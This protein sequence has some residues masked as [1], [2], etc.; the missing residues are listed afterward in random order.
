[1]ISQGVFLM[2]CNIVETERIAEVLKE[3]WKRLGVSK[4]ILTKQGT[5]FVSELGRQVSK[6]L[7]VKGIVKENKSA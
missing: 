6:L 4:E 2:L 1:M 3:M 7:T 5:Q